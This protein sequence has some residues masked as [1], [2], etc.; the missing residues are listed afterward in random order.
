MVRGESPAPAPTPAKIQPFAA[1]R[2]R[3]LAGALFVMYLFLSGSLLQPHTI[4]LFYVLSILFP[5]QPE[6]A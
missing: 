6:E 2:S 4:Y 5:L 3:V 1:P